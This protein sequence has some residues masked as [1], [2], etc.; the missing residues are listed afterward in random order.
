MRIYRVWWTL[1]D[2]NIKASLLIVSST[3]ARSHS[4][5]MPLTIDP[6]RKPNT[7]PS[8]V[9]W[10]KQSSTSQNNLVN[11][12]TESILTRWMSRSRR[13]TLLMTM[14]SILCTMLPFTTWPS[15]KNRSSKSAHTTSRKTKMILTLKHLNFHWS[16]DLKSYRIFL[17]M[18]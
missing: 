7:C 15:T 9:F 14:G 17:K 18:S 6:W 1:S 4:M 10:D 11:M 16:T 12:L 2:G 3:L 5:L 13:L 8:T